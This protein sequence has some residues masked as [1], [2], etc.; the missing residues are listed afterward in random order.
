MTAA[1][2]ATGIAARHRVRRTAMPFRRVVFA[3]LRLPVTP[4]PPR[5]APQLVPRTGQLRLVLAPQFAIAVTNQAGPPAVPAPPPTPAAPRLADA[6]IA[7]R[8]IERLVERV[9]QLE[10]RRETVPAPAT[11]A[12][13]HRPGAAPVS[14]PIVAAPLVLARPPVPAPAAPVTTPPVAAAAPQPVA[15]PASFE[16]ERLTDRV[17]ASMD[18]RI[19][20]VRERRG[21]V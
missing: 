2:F 4:R 14:R 9:H 6:R 3:R 7:G 15:V 20:A 13:G 11:A 5:T 18:R 1:A 12:L 16:I 10:V 19:L 17:L 21:H 8:Q